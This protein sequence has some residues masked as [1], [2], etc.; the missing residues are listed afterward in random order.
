MV[1][2]FVIVMKKLK[3]HV[4]HVKR[5]RTNKGGGGSKTESFEPTYFL[6]DLFAV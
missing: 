6:N 3:V 4:K 1:K 2:Y 5:K